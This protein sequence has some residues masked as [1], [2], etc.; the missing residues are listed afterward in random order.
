MSETDE[1]LNKRLHELMG[2][3]WHELTAQG[4][5][6]WYICKNCKSEIHGDPSLLQIDFVNTW[7]GFGIVW[8]FMQK[9]TEW[10]K[11]CAKNGWYIPK[12][13]SNCGWCL[14]ITL[15][16]PPAFAKK[17]VEFFEEK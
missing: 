3:C 2:L 13:E 12:I 4:L 1:Q 7:E 5:P 16:S 15:I 17:V 6:H 10:E 9:H 14:P 11:F 8:E